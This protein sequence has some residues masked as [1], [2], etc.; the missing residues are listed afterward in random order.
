MTQ[1]HEI[2]VIDYGMGNLRSVGK[3]LEHVG[4]TVYVGSNPKRLARA[5][6][7]VVPGVGSFGDAIRE[8]KKRGLI[9]VI[10]KFASDGK[11]VLGICLGLQLFFEQ[12][13]ESPGIRGLALWKGRVRRIPTSKAPNQKIPHMGWN[14]VR[15]TKKSPLVSNIR[16]GSYFYFVHSYYAVPRDKTSVVGTT[17][18][19]TSLPT[20]LA[21]GSVYAVQFHPEKSQNPG[22]QIL[23]NFVRMKR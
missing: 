15:W 7:L 9:N 23:R 5:A 10:R 18:Y 1:T 17:R 8:L 12:S 22:L 13:E 19:G 6:K 16:S 14:D 3:A 11:P 4:G 20:L 2:G 21:S